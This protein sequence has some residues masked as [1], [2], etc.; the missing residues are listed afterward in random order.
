M[1]GGGA[2]IASGPPRVLGF[3]NL[4][5]VFLSTAAVVG[6][7]ELKCMHLSHHAGKSQE[8]SP[9][10]K[11]EAAP[12]GREVL[13]TCLLLRFIYVLVIAKATTTPVCHQNENSVRKMKEGH[14]KC[15]SSST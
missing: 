9:R 13:G 8:P 7:R 1:L 3:P 14:V 15:L 2:E 11:G 5:L 4:Q 6:G 12:A 10:G